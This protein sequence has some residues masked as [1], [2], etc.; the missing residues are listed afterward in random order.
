MSGKL[1]FKRNAILSAKKIE[2]SKLIL[3][4]FNPPPPL[5]FLH[6]S[7]R[8]TLKSQDLNLYYELDYIGIWSHLFLFSTELR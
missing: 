6:V 1:N 5:L 8:K 4:F 7:V 3:I 2:V